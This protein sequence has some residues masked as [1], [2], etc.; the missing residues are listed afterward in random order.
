MNHWLTE[1]LE[2]VRELSVDDHQP[3]HAFTRSRASVD[4]EAFARLERQ[5][6]A[7]L[8]HCR[9]VNHAGLSSVAIQC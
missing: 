4:P 3:T 7:A 6:Q 9:R 8:T 2:T 1:S 5:R